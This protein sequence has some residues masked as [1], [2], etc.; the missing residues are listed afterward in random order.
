MNHGY[1]QH[2]SR[3]VLRNPCLFHQNT[4]RPTPTYYP[5]TP[6]LYTRQFSPPIQPH[7]PA[8]PYSYPNYPNYPNLTGLPIPSAIPLSLYSMPN[9]SYAQ[10]VSSKGLTMI[11]IAILVLVALDLVIVRPQKSKYEVRSLKSPDLSL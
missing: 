5:P 8:S 4:I 10:P 9:Y 1:S 3:P 6:T 11:L 7:L 2:V